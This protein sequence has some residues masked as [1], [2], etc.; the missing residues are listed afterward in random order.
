MQE[1]ARKS[2]LSESTLYRYFGTKEALVVWDEHEIDGDLK[3]RLRK[4]PPVE[5][6]RDALIHGLTQVGD[7]AF[8]LR[9]VQFIYRTPEVHAAAVRLDY[10]NRDELAQGFAQ[11]GGRKVASLQDDLLAGWCMASLDA[12]INHWQRSDGELNL[13]DLLH[14]AFSGLE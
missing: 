6:F 13:A 7:P 11:L 1:V 10:E 5:A 9:R 12:A 14:D 2:D 3:K 8:L 4:Q